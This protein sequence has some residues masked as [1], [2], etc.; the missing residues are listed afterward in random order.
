[1]FP[2][3]CIERGI[4]IIVLAVLIM[5]MITLMSNAIDLPLILDDDDVVDD[6]VQSIAS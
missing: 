2:S 6:D 1:M 3:L 5:L 4:N